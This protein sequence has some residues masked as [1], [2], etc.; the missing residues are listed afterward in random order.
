[1]RRFNIIWYITFLII[2]P[3]SILMLSGNAV[4]RV[5]AMYVYHFNDSQVVS[6]VGTYVEGEEFAESIAGYF[7][8]IKKEEFQ[9]YEENGEFKDPIFTESESQLM[10]KAKN[11]MT[12]GLIAGIVFMVSSFAIYIY[13]GGQT[14]KAGIRGLGFL[15]GGITAVEIVIMDVLLRSKGLRALLYD[16]FL[17]I[18][19]SKDSVLYILLSSPF[20]KTFSIFASVLAVVII[21]VLL[22]IHNML[23]KEKRLFS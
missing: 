17:G 16:K 5:P 10:G 7:N 23:T 12:W 1:M 4:L 3:I 2:L 13:L 19:I 18:E 6:K 21:C 8:K 9:I 20:E 14:S 11:T 15:A 22:Y